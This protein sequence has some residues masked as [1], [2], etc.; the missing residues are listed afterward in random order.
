[1]SCKF[2]HKCASCNKW[3]HGAHNCR[4]ERGD[5]RESFDSETGE[6]SRYHHRNDRSNDKDREHHRFEKNDRYHFYKKK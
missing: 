1:M 3:G 2:D 4:K 5:Y 6:K